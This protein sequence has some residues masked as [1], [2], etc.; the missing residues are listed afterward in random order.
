LPAAWLHGTPRGS[1]RNNNQGGMHDQPDTGAAA[2][3]SRGAVVLTPRAAAAAAS[4]CCP[5]H[6]MAGG[7]FFELDQPAW[8]AAEQ[9]ADEASWLLS[10]RTSRL[11]LRGAAGGALQPGVGQQRG[12]SASA[13]TS[14]AGVRTERIDAGIGTA[15]AAT[16]RTTVGAPEHA[17]LQAAGNCAPKAVG[18]PGAGRLLLQRPAAVPRL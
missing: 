11:V 16:H 18:V 13:N 8:A 17:S 4:G 14:S 9:A 1:A 10:S 15:P 7:L 12:G 2:A 3:R 5:V 6:P